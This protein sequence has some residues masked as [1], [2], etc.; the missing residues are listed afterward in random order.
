MIQK[1]FFEI[2]K[3]NNFW[4]ELTDNSAKK[5]ALIIAV[6]VPKAAG[7]VVVAVAIALVALVLPL[8]KLHSAI[9]FHARRI[10]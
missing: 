5:E 2:M 8:V 4:G 7:L 6:I 1:M 3:I 10:F 9:T